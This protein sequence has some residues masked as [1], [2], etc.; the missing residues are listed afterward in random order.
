MPLKSGLLTALG[1]CYTALWKVIVVYADLC[2]LCDTQL[3][4]VASCMPE[5]C[6]LVRVSLH[7]FQRVCAGVVLLEN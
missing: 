1:D 4:A 3:I 6:Q 2:N 5:P 7:A